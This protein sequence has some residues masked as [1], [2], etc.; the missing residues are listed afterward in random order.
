MLEV[1][2]SIQDRPPDSLAPNESPMFSQSPSAGQNGLGCPLLVEGLAGLAAPS[3]RQKQSHNTEGPRRD[4]A[5]RA[6][7]AGARLVRS[8]GEGG[9]VAPPRGRW[10]VAVNKI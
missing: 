8:W 7:A 1:G 4:S 3:V 10:R 5:V 6:R 9:L 2:R